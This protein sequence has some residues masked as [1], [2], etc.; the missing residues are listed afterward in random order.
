[1]AYLELA[2]NSDTIVEQAPEELY[3]FIPEDATGQNGVWVREDYFDHLTD[4]EWERTMS[5]LAD[6]QPDMMNGIFDRMRE[7]I[8]ARRERRADRKEGRQES[9]MGRIE[10]R[11]GGIFG[12]KLKNLIGSFLPDF[13]GGQ[14]IPADFPTRGF[15]LDVGYQTPS[16]FE[17]N[18]GLVIGGVLLLAVGGTVLALKMGKDDKKKK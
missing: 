8:A 18:K 1:M 11:E 14:Q 9:R 10:G 5:G 2:E 12:G 6:F 7:N 13:G 17:R 3:I 4:D 16:F 15:D